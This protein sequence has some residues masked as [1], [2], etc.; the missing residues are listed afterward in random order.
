M[1][2]M[3][4]LKPKAPSL[5]VI[6]SACNGTG[7]QAVAQPKQL[8]RRIYPPPCSKCSGKGRITPA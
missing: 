2:A 4:N 5:E 8:G 6:C 7:F 3:K 1:I